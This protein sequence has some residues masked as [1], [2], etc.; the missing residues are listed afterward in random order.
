MPGLLQE[1]CAPGGGLTHGGCGPNGC[2]GER[3]RALP[4]AVR[5]YNDGFYRSPR[6]GCSCRLTGPRWSTW[7]AAIGDFLLTTH[8]RP[9]ADGIGSLMA[10]AEVLRQHGKQVQPV[11]A[12]AWPPRYDFL[13][14]DKAD[15]TLCR[16]RRQLGRGRGGHRA[17][18]RHVEPAW[19][20]RPVPGPADRRQGRDRPSPLAG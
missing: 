19:R 7:C 5:S 9:D 10:L 3:A 13:D 12:S 2:P 6:R 1:P 15:R 16:A 18:H 11:I 17:G 14:P 4:F 8:V 20:L